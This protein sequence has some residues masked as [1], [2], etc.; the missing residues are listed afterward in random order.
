MSAVALADAYNAGGVTPQ[1][2]ICTPCVQVGG[3]TWC[4]NLP[5]FGKKCFHVPSLGRWHACCKTKFGW[6]P[7]SC[8]IS[9]C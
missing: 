2:Q 3:G 5:F 8:G 6:P 4:V 9:H 7:V 1:I